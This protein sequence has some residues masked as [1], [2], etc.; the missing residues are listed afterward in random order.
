MIKCSCGFGINLNCLVHGVNNTSRQ[1]LG[2][3]I[4]QK[5]YHDKRETKQGLL[6]NYDKCVDCG[7][8]IPH[9]FPKQW[10]F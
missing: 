9:N 7:L 5:C 1:N 8:E 10:N 3:S 2:E 4:L 6:E